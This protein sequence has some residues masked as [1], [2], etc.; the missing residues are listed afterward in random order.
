MDQKAAHSSISLRRTNI[1]RT[2]ISPEELR[3]LEIESQAQRAAE[4]I[5]Y[6]IRSAK[7]H[8]GRNVPSRY[9]DCTLE[10]YEIPHRGQKQTLDKVRD[11]AAR[12][13][14]LVKAGCCIV[15]FGTP[16]TGKDHLM[17]SLLRRAAAEHGLLGKFLAGG[18]MYAM[19]RTRGAEK[20]YQFNQLKNSSIL[21]IS[22]M[23]LP[24]ADPK[25]WELNQLF[26]LVAHR[27]DKM[28]P[29]WATIN[30]ASKDEFDTKLT[31]QAYDRLRHN[32]HFLPCFWPS[33]RSTPKPATGKEQDQQ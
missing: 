19:F 25:D 28:L 10:N 32:G 22:D 23:V 4:Q 18:E 2:P 17:V 21:A 29:T 33:Y 12:L 1:I 14:A 5:E 30:V 3:R 26:E 9:R 6:A 8:F 15:W 24:G 27:Y 11:L 20:E 7:L 13:P 31:P 16:G